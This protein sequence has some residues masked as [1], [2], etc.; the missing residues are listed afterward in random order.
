MSVARTGKRSRRKAAELHTDWKRL[1]SLADAQIHAAVTADPE[2]NPT[3][4]GFWATAKVVLPR[5]KRT[6]T[7]R[8]DADLLDW[9][10]ANRGYQT[11]INTILRAYMN[12]QLHR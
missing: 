5:P 2:A 10:R 1:R 4:E 9:F 12:A 8:L 7:M 11:R 3:D 6:I